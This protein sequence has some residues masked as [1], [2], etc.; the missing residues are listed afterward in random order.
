ML[1]RTC[2]GEINE[3]EIKCPL[4][5]ENEEKKGGKWG[6]SVAQWESEERERG[7]WVGRSLWFSDR[8]F[9]NH[10]AGGGGGSLSVKPKT[11]P[12]IKKTKVLEWVVFCEVWVHVAWSATTVWWSCPLHCKFLLVPLHICIMCWLMMKLF[13]FW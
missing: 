6:R 5:R 2:S 3:N 7:K 8:D 4:E 1:V 9:G 10:F 13:S 11:V 12:I